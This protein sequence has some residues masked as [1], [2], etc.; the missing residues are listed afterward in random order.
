MMICSRAAFDLLDLD[1]AAHF[2]AAAAGVKIVPDALQAAQ[3]MQPVGK[4]GPLT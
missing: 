4:S 3:S 1:F 2:E